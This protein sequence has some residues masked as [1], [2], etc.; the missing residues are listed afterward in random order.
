MYVSVLVLPFLLSLTFSLRVWIFAADRCFPPSFFPP[1]AESPLL[2]SHLDR[3]EV[4]YFV[5]YVVLSV[6]AVCGV[7]DPRHRT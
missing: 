2:H 3:P 7:K 6:R 4:G 5:Y 1:R